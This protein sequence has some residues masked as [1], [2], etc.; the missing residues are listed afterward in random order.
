M[1][2]FLAALFVPQIPQYNFAI[3]KRE[4]AQVREGRGFGNPHG[5]WILDYQSP[6]RRRDG[7][8]DNGKIDKADSRGSVVC[9]AI[10]LV[11]WANIRHVN[12]KQDVAW[13]YDH[14][15]ANYATKD[16]FCVGAGGK[17]IKIGL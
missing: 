9:A 2:E 11:A 14:G 3:P 15:Y 10:V 6:P 1:G 12:Y 17:L 8:R 16:G 7:R 4:P 5:R 13:C